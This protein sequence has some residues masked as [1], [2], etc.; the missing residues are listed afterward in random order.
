MICGI[1]PPLGIEHSAGEART[2]HQYFGFKIYF[3]QARVFSYP[4]LWKRDREIICPYILGVCD[5]IAI[6]PDRLDLCRQRRGYL[7]AVD[8][9]IF[10]FQNCA[11][12]IGEG[13]LF[14]GSDVLRRQ[15]G[16]EFPAE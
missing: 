9:A 14:S 10:G 1:S 7:Q 8:T 2:V 12:R 11:H 15:L 5:W 13:R 3:E 16:D 6:D 4:V